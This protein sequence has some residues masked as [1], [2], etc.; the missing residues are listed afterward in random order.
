L[1]GAARCSGI[2]DDRTFLDCYYGA[3]QPLRAKLGLP[4]AP[5]SQQILVPPARPGAPVASAAPYPAAPSAAPGNAPPPAERPG[6]FSRMF[7]HTEIKAEAPTHMTSYKFEGG[8]FFTVTL[9]NGEVWRQ[10]TGDTA[11]AKWRARPESYAVTILPG[12]GFG[13]SRMKVGSK[14]MYEVERVR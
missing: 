5:G 10:S 7:T 11:T 8:G 1:G 4:P 6:F 9:A 14:E 13:T 3:A 12:A 2:A